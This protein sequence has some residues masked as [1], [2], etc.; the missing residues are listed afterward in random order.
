MLSK[1]EKVILRS[2][3]FRHLDGIVTCPAAHVLHEKG[4]TDY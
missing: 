2:K 3:L 1:P 4:I